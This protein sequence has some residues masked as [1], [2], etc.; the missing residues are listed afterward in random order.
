MADL[1]L[2][3]TLWN[4]LISAAQSW[5]FMVQELLGTPAILR[6]IRYP[7]LSDFELSKR[8]ALTNEQII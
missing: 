8:S 6:S 2:G 7:L 3:N 5:N 4:P 1:A